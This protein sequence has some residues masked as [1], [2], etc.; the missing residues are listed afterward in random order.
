MGD[1]LTAIG[2]A[3]TLASPARELNQSPLSSQGSQLIEL[4]I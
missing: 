1:L 3:F 2:F 4:P